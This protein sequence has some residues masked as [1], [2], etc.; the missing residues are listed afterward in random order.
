MITVWCPKCGSKHRRY[1]KW[2]VMTNSRAHIIIAC[3][4]C[5][6]TGRVTLLRWILAKIGV[7]R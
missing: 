2:R 3:G 1:N 6:G 4:Y 7:R 5:R